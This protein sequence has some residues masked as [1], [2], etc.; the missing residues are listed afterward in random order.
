[1][2]QIGYKNK[3]FVNSVL[4]EIKLSDF[5]HKWLTKLKNN[6]LIELPYFEDSIN[7]LS[8]DISIEAIRNSWENP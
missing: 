4:F 3:F 1:M 6:E 7:T 2:Q 5:W 8:K